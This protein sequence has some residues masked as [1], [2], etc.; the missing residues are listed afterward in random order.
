MPCLSFQVILAANSY[1]AIN[2]V[3]HSEL[4]I[5]GDRVAEICPTIR[6][7]ALMTLCKL[8]VELH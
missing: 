6:L 7:D 8:K 4:V 5:L 1:P 2:D 3:I